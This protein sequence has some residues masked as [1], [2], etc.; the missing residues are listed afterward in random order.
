MSSSYLACNNFYSKVNFKQYEEW[1]ELRSKA[2][3]VIGLSV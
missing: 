2:S 1:I 3:D